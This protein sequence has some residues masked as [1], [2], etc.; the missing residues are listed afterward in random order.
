M[1]MNI[2][3]AAGLICE[4]QSMLISQRDTGAWEFPGGKIE[5]GEDPRDTVR[6]EFFE[7]LGLEVKVGPIFEVL[8]YRY[9]QRVV[10]VLVFLCRLPGSRA[11]R[12]MDGP[13]SARWVAVDQL[14]S[15]DFLPA[16]GP[17][18]GKIA[19]APRQFLEKAARLWEDA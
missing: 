19:R 16:D 3:V 13:V 1:N 14:E 6:R 4:D 2:Y 9:P 17:L 15:D 10:T 8:H 18:I 5:N 11:F 7:E 12:C